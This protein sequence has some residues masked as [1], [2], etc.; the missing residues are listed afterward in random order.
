MAS[1]SPLFCVIQILE[2]IKLV[3]VWMQRF[4]ICDFLSEKVGIEWETTLH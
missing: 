1:K 2:I 3:V 4:E